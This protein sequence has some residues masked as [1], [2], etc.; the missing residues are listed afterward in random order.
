MVK[1]TTFS[2]APGHYVGEVQAKLAPQF[3]QWVATTA[4]NDAQ[5]A[6]LPVLYLREGASGIDTLRRRFSKPL[7]LLT[8][9]VILTHIRKQ[10][11]QR[12]S[13]CS[14]GHKQ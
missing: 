7:Y 2:I 10:E 13:L 8:T 4:H 14:L 3:Q 6:N 11:P 5:R 9:L 12:K 1:R